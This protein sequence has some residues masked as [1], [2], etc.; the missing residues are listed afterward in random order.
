MPG[1]Y[2]LLLWQYFMISS[3]H[4]SVDFNE[5]KTMPGG[6]FLCPAEPVTTTRGFDS[7]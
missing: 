7:G 3:I 5:S 1:R 6:K 4:S 2:L